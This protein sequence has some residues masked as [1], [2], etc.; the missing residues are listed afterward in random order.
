MTASA[1]RMTI[2]GVPNFCHAGLRREGAR[3]TTFGGAVAG[4]GAV[5]MCRALLERKL[6]SLTFADRF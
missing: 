1:R 4:M 3:S 2:M 5:A 6:I